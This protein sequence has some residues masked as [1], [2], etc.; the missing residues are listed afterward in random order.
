MNKANEHDPLDLLTAAEAGPLCKISPKS[1][2]YLARTNQIPF[3]QFGSKI[4][5]SRKELTAWVEKQHGE[6]Y[7]PPGERQVD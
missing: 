4:R 6:P 2:G 7:R 5:F 3:V 1:M